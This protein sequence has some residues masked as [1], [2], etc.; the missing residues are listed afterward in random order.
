MCQDYIYDKDME[1]I[2][3]DEQRKA[4]KMQGKRTKTRTLSQPPL[5]VHFNDAFIGI[6]PGAEI[7]V[8]TNIRVVPPAGSP[9]PTPNNLHGWCK[10]YI[11]DH[12]NDLG[13]NSR[14][15]NISDIYTLPRS[16]NTKA[17]HRCLKASPMELFRWHSIPLAN[18]RSH[19]NIVCF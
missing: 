18:F 6:Q 9:H 17:S 2:A 13:M 19:H 14:R 8:T 3:K 5:H 15:E 4:W 16:H 1:Q 7:C 10:C 12:V 11:K